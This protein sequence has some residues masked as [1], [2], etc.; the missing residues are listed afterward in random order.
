LS[1]RCHQTTHNYKNLSGS[2]TIT[3]PIHPLHGQSVVVRCLRQVGNLVKV[4]VEHP[5]G[6]LLSIPASETSLEVTQPVSQISGQT[7]LFDPKKLQSLARWM[8]TLDTAIMEEISSGQQHQ[9]VVARK[10][11]DT[12]T[13]SPQSLAKRSKRPHP[14]LDQSDSEVGGQNARPTTTGTDATEETN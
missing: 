14:A 2:V 8:A 13:Q 4:I 10:F 11:D 12:A 9:D 1:G 5:D 6:G 3:N 7:P